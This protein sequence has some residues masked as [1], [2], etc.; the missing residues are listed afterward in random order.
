MRACMRVHSRR[1][2]LTLDDANYI[3]VCAHC[4]YRTRVNERTD[5]Q[6]KKKQIYLHISIVRV[7]CIF[8]ARA[9]VC[10]NM[11]MCVC[12]CSFECG[13]LCVCVYKQYACVDMTYVVRIH[14]YG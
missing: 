3:I 8:G 5:R 2:A 4:V 14:G 11:S 10:A 1:V 6:R 7:V 13:P 12:A 9:G